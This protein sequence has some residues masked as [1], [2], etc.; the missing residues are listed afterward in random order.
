MEKNKKVLST[1]IAAAVLGAAALVTIAGGANAASQVE[2]PAPVSIVA[3]AADTAVEAPGTET[4][5]DAT[6][7]NEAPGTETA[8]ATGSN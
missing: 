1:T 4:A 7:A 8:D 3:P 2:T 5:D 6:E